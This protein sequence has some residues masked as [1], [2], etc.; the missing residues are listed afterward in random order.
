MRNKYHEI[1]Y[2][3]EVREPLA[4]LTLT[5]EEKR[6]GT[7]LIV[8][9]EGIFTRHQKATDSFV[10]FF[11]R[12]EKAS[13]LMSALLEHPFLTFF[14]ELLQKGKSPTKIELHEIDELV[15]FDIWDNQEER[16]LDRMEKEELCLQYDIPIVK[17]YATF[18]YDEKDFLSLE[19][20][21]LEKAKAE[22]RE[23][24]VFKNERKH[25]YF[26]SKW[27]RPKLSKEP[28]PVDSRP[29]IPESEVF[30][31]IAKAEIDLGEDFKDKTKA[32]PLIARYVGE[33]CRKHGF[34][35]TKNLFHYYCA[36]LDRNKGEG[37]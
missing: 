9:R 23:G 19:A 18:I 13:H 24:V 12:I 34:K 3:R 29:E 20:Q 8:N 17:Q 15:L 10:K 30:G 7:C 5:A 27:E 2:K 25:I 6:D 1:G 4:G 16:W 11:Q 36:Y 35:R 21:L 33:E 32:M 28:K 31:A 14:I 26:K 37:E 22:S